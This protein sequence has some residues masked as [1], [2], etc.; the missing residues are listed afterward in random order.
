LLEKQRDQV[1]LKKMDPDERLTKKMIKDREEKQRT[2][3]IS[4]YSQMG[5]HFTKP[6]GPRSD[7]K[8]FNMA[9]DDTPDIRTHRLSMFSGDFNN[10]LRRTTRLTKNNSPR[11]S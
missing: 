2:D 6:T 10:L 3:K 1:K 7:K 11:I 8:E 5:V 4:Y 9:L